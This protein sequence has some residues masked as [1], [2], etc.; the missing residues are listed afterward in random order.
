MNAIEMQELEDHKALEIQ[1][2]ASMTFTLSWSDGRAT[3]EDEMHIE[4]FSV[5]READF[6]PVDI[7]LKIVGMRAGDRVE[8]ALPAGELTGTWDAARQFSADASCFD[9]NYRRGLQVEPR[10]G[11]FYPQGFF[12]GVHGVVRE[13]LEPARI[14]ALDGETMRVDLNHPFA[15]FPVQVEAKLN[16][17]LPGSDRR[18]G[19]C[20]SPLDDLVRY[21]G[22]AAPLPDGT[23]TDFGDS[24]NGMSRMDEREDH[25]F[26]TGPRMVQHL[27]ARALETVNALYRRLIPAGADV[28]DLMASYDSHLQG[29]SP[30]S[31]RVLGLNAQELDAN[32]AA[33]ARL[34]Q[35]LN[36]SSTLPLDDASV[37]AVVCTASVEYLVQPREIFTEV[38]RI[39]RPGGVF[40]TSFSNRWFPTKAIQ[41]WGELHE[42]ERVGMVTQWF[43]QAGFHG[44]HTLSSRGWA[45]PQNDPHYGETA[46]SDPVYAVWGF[47]PSDSD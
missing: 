18:G 28:L 32:A 6:L 34:V 44:L 23:P 17:V 46:V 33:T 38:L 4:K 27:D 42:F 5:W 25:V 41:I 47:K 43:Q 36:Q 9:R 16:R 24:G 13:A 15:R 26:Y 40:V 14:V 31:F 1:G 8:A 11:R 37:D 29:C 3:H 2:L 45:R 22:L 21:P 12:H 7:G 39:L 30:N 35:D 19:R 10:C 20:V